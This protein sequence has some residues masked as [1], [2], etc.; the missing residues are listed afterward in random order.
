[1]RSWA[2]RRLLPCAV[3]LLLAACT[4]DP[5]AAGR[6]PTGTPP[7]SVSSPTVTPTPTTPE[8]EVE[9]AVRTYYAELTRAAQT[10]DTS[11]LKTLVSRSCPCYRAIRVIDDNG[12]EG[13]RARGA[14]FQVMSMKVLEQL[15]GTALV[16]VR[17]RSSDY[18]VFDAK[19]KVVSRIPARRMHLTLDL[20]RAAD[21]HWVVS[22]LF[23]LEGD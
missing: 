14:K 22:N 13:E 2:A 11:R 8:E 16:E 20:F 4:A 7:A 12:R 19:G 18:I 1:M 6:V 3:V 9:A 17:T 5:P 10:N 21:S 23:D 15:K